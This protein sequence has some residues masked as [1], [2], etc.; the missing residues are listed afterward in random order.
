MTTE[1]F[2]VPGLTGVYLEDSF[3]LEVRERPGEL[4]LRME[5]VLTQGHPRYRAPGADEQYCYAD[6]WLVLGGAARI[7]WEQR[8]P[9]R[10]TDAAGEEDLG[11]VDELR[12]VGGEWVVAGDWGRV[13]VRTEMQPWLEWIER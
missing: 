8:S 12:R 7:E 13:R 11:N 1:Y 5:V 6:A 4:R 2:E 9:R 10:F 3:V